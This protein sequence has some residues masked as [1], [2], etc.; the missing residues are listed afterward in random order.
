MVIHEGYVHREIHNFSLSV[1]EP[2][3]EKLVFRQYEIRESARTHAKMCGD[4]M[5]NGDFVKKKAS[6]YLFVILRF[7]LYEFS[8]VL[9]SVLC[10]FEV[11]PLLSQYLL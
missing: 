10:I 5:E 2:I 4:I 7:L 8:L 3:H 11:S 9:E 1:L 6:K